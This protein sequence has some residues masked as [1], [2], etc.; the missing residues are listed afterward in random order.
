MARYLGI[1]SRG[2]S[3]APR[4]L[5]LVGTTALAIAL[6][7][8]MHHRRQRP[9]SD[10]TALI[11]LREGDSA[12]A[13]WK[14]GRKWYN[15]TVIAANS[16][17]TYSLRYADGDL[18]DKVP[19]DRIRTVSGSPL[20]TTALALAEGKQV[21]RHAVLPQAVDPAFLRAL[22]PKI[23]SIFKPQIVKY[24]NTNPDIE[25][26]DGSHGHIEWKVHEQL[27]LDSIIYVEPFV[28]R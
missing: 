8:Y 18:W 6:F 26:A 14:V 22:L 13:L 1:L 4:T 2:M 3:C 17:G 11:V 20:A 16:D 27:F 5:A 21:L 7:L 10:D 12:Q 9:R 15:V 19:A 28:D 24:S 25:Q 23:Q